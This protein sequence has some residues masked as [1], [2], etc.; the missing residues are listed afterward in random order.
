MDIPSSDV[1]EALVVKGDIK[2]VFAREPGISI[3][4]S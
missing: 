1:Y 4:C 3:F 2:A